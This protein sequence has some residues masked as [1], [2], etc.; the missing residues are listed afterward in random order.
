M[1]NKVFSIDASRL[2]YEGTPGFI[3]PHIPTE[4]F[5]LIVDELMDA[6]VAFELK[7]GS[8]PI[9]L[10]VEGEMLQGRQFRGLPVFRATNGVLEKGFMFV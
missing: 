1:I 9:G 2:L 7:Y 6:F 10:V 5:Q 4:V 8:V 3:Q